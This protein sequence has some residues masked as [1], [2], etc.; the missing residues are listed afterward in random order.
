MRVVR[1]TKNRERVLYTEKYGDKKRSPT[2]ES[3]PRK[4]EKEGESGRS[5]V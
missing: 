3:D 2:R 4:G 1:A 5:F